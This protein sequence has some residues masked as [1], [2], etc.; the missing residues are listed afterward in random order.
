MATVIRNLLAGGVGVVAAVATVAA[1]EA[2]RAHGLSGTRWPRCIGQGR[3][4][5]LYSVNAGWRVFG[6][7]CWWFLAVDV[8]T[9]AAVLVSRSRP[10]SFA[11]VI[12]A[13]RLL[14]AI[15]NFAL[16]AHPRWFMG[17]GLATVIM[18]TLLASWLAVRTA[19]NSIKPNPLRGSA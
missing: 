8:G 1:V 9:P 6:H 2:N 14:A 16:I 10:R 4:G 13:V 15:L 5:S 17:F 19:N 11:L 18:A 7:S 12:G 3:T